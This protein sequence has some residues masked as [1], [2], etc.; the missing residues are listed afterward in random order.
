MS[1]EKRQLNK[2]KHATVNQL[3]NQ[4]LAKTTRL[5]SLV[6]KYEEPPKVINE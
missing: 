3:M 1:A 2:K 6:T 5:F 4:S